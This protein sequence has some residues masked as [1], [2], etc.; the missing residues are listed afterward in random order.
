M[1]QVRAAY[2]M[3]EILEVEVKFEKERPG[4]DVKEAFM[5][6]EKSPGLQDLCDQY[7]KHLIRVESSASSGTWCEAVLHFVRPFRGEEQE[8]S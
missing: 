7:P 2:K 8:I 5:K 6:A 1:T 3:Q 4:Q